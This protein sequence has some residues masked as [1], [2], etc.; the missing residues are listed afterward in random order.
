[1][2]ALLSLLSIAWASSPVDALDAVDWNAAGEEAAQVLSE[3]LRIDTTNP[4][5]R[6]EAAVEFL[7]EFLRREGIAVARYPFA[8][9]RASLVARIEGRTDAPA[10]CLL[11]H[12][13]VASAEPL[14]W[15]QGHA[16]FSGDIADGAVWGRGALDMKGFGAVQLL[17]LAW[18]RRLNI[19]LE[20]DL[21]LVAVGDEEVDNTGIRQLADRW[22]E[23]G[24]DRVLNEGGIGVKDLFF[25][26]QT[27]YGV[28][29]AEKGVLWL[30]MIARGEPGHGST[31]RSGTA[32]QRLHDAVTS[33][34][35]FR[36]RPRLHPALDVL[37]Q[38]VG[39]ERGGFSGWVLRHR[40]GVALFV[41]P[42]LLADPST[43]AAIS[44]TC[45]LTGW[46]G[47]AQPNVV[48]SEAWAS[49]DCRVLPGTSTSDLLGQLRRAVPDPHVDFE[50]IHRFEANESSWEDP[51]FQVLERHL[52]AGRPGVVV[53]PIVSVGST[54]STY[55][56]P[57]GV[58]AYGI[59]PFEV[60]LDELTT[61]HGNNE[62]ITVTNLRDGL[63]RLLAITVDFTTA[64]P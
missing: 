49:L 62:R 2:F 1:M 58:R 24:C 7:G 50:V 16:P 47:A 59:E 4:P 63:Q 34:R 52:V 33:F 13:D 14:G 43:R 51:L 8:S 5:G 35:K 31:P 30:K 27:V 32:P 29:V 60:N 41:R 42:R 38:R 57:L 44:D 40:W 15:N 18:V 64:P 21:V 36:T 12:T 9:G 53:G 22:D 61:M 17:T 46:G 11:S 48:L 39:R 3:Y 23:I 54:D 56:R 26:G 28:S 19:P 45:N 37:F 6:E 25:P 20:R 10:L 55:L